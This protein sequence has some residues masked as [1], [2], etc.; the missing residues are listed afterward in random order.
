MLEA[1]LE[2][3]QSL[4]YAVATLSSVRSALPGFLG[5]LERKHLRDVRAVS[6]RDVVSYALA[7]ATARTR[8]GGILTTNSRRAI[9][10]RVRGFFG[11]LLKEG[12]VL[13][14]PAA[15]LP[16]PRPHRLPH[17][18]LSEAQAR[19]LM[20]APHP[21]T[22][23]GERDRA[24][25]EVLYGS[26][27]RASECRR[28]DLGDLDLGRM[29]LLVRD[30]KGRKDR[31]VPL[32]GRA[33]RALD[34]YLR[35]ARPDAAKNAREPALFLSKYGRRLSSTQLR[36]TVVAHAQSARIPRRVSPHALRH[37]CATH[38]LEGGADV[39]HVQAILGHRRLET[40]ALY[41]EVQGLS[42]AKV[43]ERSHPRAR[44]TT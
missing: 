20:A 2:H 27:L 23:T 37:A 6:E 39:R 19:R 25:L 28:L 14:D 31:F 36:T 1:Y 12:V 42:L 10:S 11:F 4:R 43:I 32:T 8:R 18:V 34:I 3:L 40:T 9:L 7:L 44:Q 21:S 5:H 30:G 26:G 15:Q 22:R 24:L 35:E 29:T 17:H 41:T 33:A 38:L 16:L 13:R